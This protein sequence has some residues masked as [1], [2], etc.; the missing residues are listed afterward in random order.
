LNPWLSITAGEAPL[1]LSMPHSGIELLNLAPRLVSPWRARKDADWHIPELYAF[2]AQLGATIVRTRLS[3]TVI[4]VNRD[5]SGRSLYPGMATTEL[6]PTTTFDGEPLYR[7][8]QAP[9]AEEI[10]QR[11]HDYFDP[12]HEALRA[13]TDRLL[14]RHPR[15]VVYD[16]HSIRSAIPRLFEGTLP[17]FNIGTNSD[18]AC[19]PELSAAIVAACAAS[20]FSHVLNG[21]FKGG[22]ITRSLGNPA[23]GVHAVQM[24]LSCRGYLREPQG[25]VSAANWPAAF[26]PDF[27]APLQSV[28]RDVLQGCL[29]F[30]IRSL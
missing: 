26:D 19:A 2:A 21:R 10:A 27:A 29:D 7:D 20:R 28:L 24:E 16:C 13:Q 23:R 22:H 12:Y 17:Q 30:A 11:R 25:A 15:V 4:D 3:R 18:A 1:I 6:C 8:G 5:P 14:A 9:G